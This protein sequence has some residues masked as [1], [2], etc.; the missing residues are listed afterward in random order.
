MDDLRAQINS[1]NNTSVVDIDA[2]T[3][4]IKDIRLILDEGVEKAMNQTNKR[5]TVEHEQNSE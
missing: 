1:A 4:W 2:T 5:N 3:Q